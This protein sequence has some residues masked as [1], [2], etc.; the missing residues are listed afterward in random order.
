MRLPS[1]EGMFYKYSKW[2]RTLLE[3]NT[4]QMVKIVLLI[5]FFVKVYFF[6]L[7]NN[8]V[9]YFFRGFFSNALN[10][11]K[12]KTKTNIKLFINKKTKIG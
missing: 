6:K 7:F 1:K 12:V 5:Q 8:C 9:L 3:G 2:Y 10:G 4:L 11:R